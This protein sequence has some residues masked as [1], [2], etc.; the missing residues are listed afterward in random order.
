MGFIANIEG[1]KFK[2]GDFTP[3]REVAEKLRTT[4]ATI[5]RWLKE[6]KVKT[7]IWGR[8]RRQW[9]FVKTDD[10]SKLKDYK[11]SINRS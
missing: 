5:K 8:D 6:E 7:V 2:V 11:E 10:I 1:K 4:P 9:I 3:V